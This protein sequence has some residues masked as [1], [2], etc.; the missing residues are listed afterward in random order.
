MKR[1]CLLAGSVCAEAFLLYAIFIAHTLT[2]VSF[3][4]VEQAHIGVPGKY[5]SNFHWD[6]LLSTWSAT[7][8]VMLMVW[9][10]A[11]ATAWRFAGI[12]PKMRTLVQPPV[13]SVSWPAAS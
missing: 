5:A 2:P 12:R 9:L 4:L 1:L 10:A 7:L 11:R 13:I 6:G 3:Y 8:V